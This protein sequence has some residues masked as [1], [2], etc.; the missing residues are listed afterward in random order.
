MKGLVKQ[1]EIV[2][3]ESELIS[4]WKKTSN[5]WPDCSSGE[6]ESW[7]KHLSHSVTWQNEE[8]ETEERKERERPDHN[9][10]SCRKLLFDYSISCHL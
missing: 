2:E 6:K 1:Q 7:H 8:H 3:R 5:G 4:Q 10:L 9:S